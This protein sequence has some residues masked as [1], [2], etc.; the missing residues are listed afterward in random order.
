MD[1]SFSKIVMNSKLGGESQKLIIPE[2]RMPLSLDL[3]DNING[4]NT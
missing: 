4:G 3:I 1:K 2:I